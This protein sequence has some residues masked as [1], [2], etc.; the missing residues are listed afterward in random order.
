MKNKET[1]KL[2]YTVSDY[3]V[4]AIASVKVVSTTAV[5]GIEDIR[6]NDADPSGEW[7]DLN[8]RKLDKRPA[9]KGVYVFKGMKVIVNK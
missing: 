1:S 5:K 2:I 8:G 4:F 9:T 6:S 7:H 3:F